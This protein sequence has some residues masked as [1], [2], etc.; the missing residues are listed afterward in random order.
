ML[1][2]PGGLARAS[3]PDT[4]HDAAAQV[5]VTACEAAVMAALR[6]APV[7]GL[8]TWEIADLVPGLGWGSIT[9]RMRPLENKGW[10]V[11]SGMRRTPKGRYRPQI[12]WLAKVT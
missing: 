12:V 9:P 3:D 10:V 7:T 5:N 8:T 11:R 1:S 4:S 2:E 6:T